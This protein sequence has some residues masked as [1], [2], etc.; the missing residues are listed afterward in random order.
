M[1]I[2]GDLG[3]TDVASLLRGMQQERATGT[4]SV[5]GGGRACSLYFL[6]GHLFHAVG[7]GQ[8]GEAAVLEALG[9]HSG[10]FTFDARAKLPPEETIT[11]STADLLAEWDRRQLLTSAAAAFDDTPP[12]APPEPPAATPPEPALEPG[13]AAAPAAAAVGG[14]RA[15]FEATFP[16]P[17]EERT[18]AATAPSS[19][20]PSPPA[21][22]VPAFA[23]SE[24]MATM[25]T[26]PAVFD[27]AP[28]RPAVA[29]SAPLSLTPAARAIG[30]PNSPGLDVLLPLPNGVPQNIGLKSN[31]LN[32]PR[33]LRAISDDHLTGYIRLREDGRAVAHLLMRAGD[34][35]AASHQDAGGVQA[36]GEALGRMAGDI[37]AG[38]GL[39]DVVTLE[40]PITLAIG[41]LVV[42]TPMLTGLP[43]RIV[44]FPALLEYLG[45]EQTTGAL[46]VVTP[47]D[48]G[49][50][51]L[52]DGGVLGGYTLTR[53]DQV[54]EPDPVSALCTDRAAR[55]EVLRCQPRDIPTALDL[56]AVDRAAAAAS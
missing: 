12:G 24:V 37:A 29:P 50:L 3:A 11:A 41:R 49:V 9:W 21:P 8:E 44:T 38:R 54:A 31:F 30:A 43:A 39:V 6:F 19:P 13:G 40:D 46:V 53:P 28:A 51:L 35:L 55:I 42:A 1:Q 15:D 34:V 20:E 33:M 36:G 14:A 27:D 52:D 16:A 26:P 10:S 7:D 22:P 18:W 5:T 32:F 23:P 47:S 56:A 48:R 45:E 4:L 2:Q 25:S 17:A